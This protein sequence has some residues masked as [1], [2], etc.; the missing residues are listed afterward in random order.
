MIQNTWKYNM[1]QICG[2]KIQFSYKQCVHDTFF[3]GMWPKN[4]LYY[5]VHLSLNINV[6]G[7]IVWNLEKERS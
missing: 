7:V 1:S 6:I 3:Y 5:K 2:K 4:Y